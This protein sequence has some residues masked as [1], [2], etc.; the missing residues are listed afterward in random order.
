LARQPDSNPGRRFEDEYDLMNDARSSKSSVET[1]GAASAE[2][3]T[4]DGIDALDRLAGLADSVEGR[5]ESRRTTPITPERTEA[6]K[7]ASRE[8][9]ERVSRLKADP[10]LLTV[11]ALGGTGVGKSSLLNALAGARIAESGL[12]RPTT[13]DP[14]AYHH[15]DVDVDR[16]S[17]LFR[18][19]RSVKHDR[20]ELR[21]LVIID[22][23]DMD[24][25]VAEHRDRL[26]KILPIADAVLYVGSQEKYHDRGVWDVM[27][28]HRKSRGFAFVLNKWDRC[29]GDPNDPSGVS[30]VDDL[31]AGLIDAGFE[32]PTVFRTIAYAWAKARIENK[33]VD[34]PVPDD[35]LELERWL[36]CGLDEL[37]IRSIKARGVGGA[38]DRMIEATAAAIPPDRAKQGEKLK[39]DWSASIRR[40]V[41]EAADYVLAGADKN[42]NEIEAH[43]SG[44][45]FGEVKGLFGYYLKTF[46]SIRS[47]LSPV[48]A[49]L[50]GVKIESKMDDIAA[51]CV[52]SAQRGQS[53]GST[54]ADNLRSNLLRLADDVGWPVES[55]SAELS[56]DAAAALRD[57]RLRG[58]LGEELRSLERDFV[59]PTGGRWATRALIRQVCFWA[60]IV[61]TAGLILLIGY[62]FLQL[63]FFEPIV[64]SLI[65]AAATIVGLHLLVIWATKSRWTD[66]RSELARRIKSDLVHQVEPPHMSAAHVYVERYDAERKG[67]TS[68]KR[69]L[70]LARSALEK[71]V[72]ESAGKSLFA[73]VRKKS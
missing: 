45:G 19:C 30:P 62:K 2:T 24:G 72:D 40:A 28:E 59:E 20:D 25:S 73:R 56:P 65:I 21:R 66:L 32:D 35:F 67:W 13:T 48:G 61:V 52:R 10:G 4:F 7:S 43:F 22:T 47:L 46:Q 34:L 16:L 50:S 23:P 55:L 68:L 49:A 29:V 38:I 27:L 15:K 58:M 18:T 54:F 3:E 42:S 60:P 64:V 37:A 6:L 39:E 70:E 41:D 26:E 9:S 44:L 69:R 14:T 36:K 5:I 11:V 1:V 8:L 51:R 12:R 31:K 17:E 33:P 57:E 53:D 63:S 71:S